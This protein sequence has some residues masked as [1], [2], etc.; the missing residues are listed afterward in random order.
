MC[1]G[2][3][4]RCY[5]DRQRERE[6]EAERDREQRRERERQERREYERARE[7]RESRERSAQEERRHNKRL[8]KLR[9][10]EV[11]CQRQAARDAE[12]ARE[13]AEEA[14][15]I[16]GLTTF[17]CCHCQ[18]TFNEEKGYSSIESPIG[19]PVCNKCYNLL[20]KCFGCNQYYWLNDSRSTPIRLLE[21]E[22]YQFGSAYKVKNR[23][24]YICDNCAGTK[25]KVFFDEQKV[26]EKK[27]EEQERIRKEK[28]AAERAERERREAAERAE[29]ARLKAAEN[30]KD[31]EIEKRIQMRDAILE[32]EREKENADHEKKHARI[33]ALVF[34]VIA[35]AISTGLGCVLS[36]III[37]AAIGIGVL[38]FSQIFYNLASKLLNGIIFSL[39]PNA[40]ACVIL[41][42]LS[43]IMWSG[44]KFQEYDLLTLGLSFVMWVIVGAIHYPSYNCELLDV[45]KTILA[46]IKVIPIIGL[47]SVVICGVSYTTFD[48]LRPLEVVLICSWPVVAYLFFNNSIELNG[49]N[50]LF[51]GIVLG[52]FFGAIIA[53]VCA[54]ISWLFITD[55]FV[56]PFFFSLTASVSIYA[57][58]ELNR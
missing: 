31:R 11:E 53:V 22:Y 21:K 58:I 25:L 28:E 34:S 32:E 30:A 7:E 43:E 38:I 35:T 27:Y 36:E 15:R 42:L 9:E 18:G 40:I 54:A 55:T 5:G 41:V 6:R 49:F 44:I 1:E 12:K 45:F 2:L 13:E 14:R 26:L 48:T 37:G 50:K 8:E 52:G 16:A 24:D 3:C 4:G 56:V 19:K 10:E 57:L 46:Y 29:N 47:V 33:R 20:K 51:G 17:T 39:I 23:H